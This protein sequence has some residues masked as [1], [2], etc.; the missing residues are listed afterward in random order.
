V[1]AVASSNLDCAALE[2]QGLYDD[3]V[4]NIFHQRSLTLSEIACSLS[5]GR[6]YDIIV[7]RGHEVSMVIEDDSLFVPSQLDRVDLDVL[8]PG[9]DIAF[10][11]SFIESGQPRHLI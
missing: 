2:Q 8:P 9:W 10:L 11:S 6:A 1:D 7:S 4:A 5:H 3:T